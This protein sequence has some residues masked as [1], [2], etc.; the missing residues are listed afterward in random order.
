MVLSLGAFG[1]ALSGCGGSGKHSTA[2]APTQSPP[3]TP[4]VTPATGTTGTA[5]TPPIPPVSAQRLLGCLNAAGLRATGNA[6]N[7]G[8]PSAPQFAIDVGAKTEGSAVMNLNV[9]D[10]AAHARADLSA[11]QRAI[12]SAA[13]A[14]AVNGRGGVK[15]SALVVQIGNVLFRHDV[16]ALPGQ[17]STARGCVR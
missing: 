7:Q 3:L 1:V 9:Y 17:V 5:T 11:Y 16:D 13:G 12:S 8:N 4:V 6:E 14:G 10:T 2:L 15:P